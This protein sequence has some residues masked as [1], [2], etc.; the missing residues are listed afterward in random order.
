[1]ISLD[2]QEKRDNT[3]WNK[4]L[5]SSNLDKTKYRPRNKMEAK[6]DKIRKIHDLVMLVK[7]SFILWGQKK[8]KFVF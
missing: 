7:F 6:L 1:M 4:K 8:I 3:K 2:K 5:N